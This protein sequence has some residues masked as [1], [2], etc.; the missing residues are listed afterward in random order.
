MVPFQTDDLRMVSQQRHQS[1]RVW[2]TV[3][4]ITQANHAILWSEIES[5]EKGSEGG[6]VAVNVAHHV[7]AVPVVKTCL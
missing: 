7:E 4:H 6:Q 3:D 5:V 2:S 1:G